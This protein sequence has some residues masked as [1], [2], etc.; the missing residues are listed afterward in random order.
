MAVMTLKGQRIGDQ[1]SDPFKVAADCRFDPVALPPAIKFVRFA[2]RKRLLRANPRL[3]AF[4]LC[5]L[6]SAYPLISGISS[7][8]ALFQF[9][10]SIFRRVASELALAPLLRIGLQR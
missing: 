3:S 8:L 4:A 7:G 1:K 2:N 9:H 10:K 5:F 6:P